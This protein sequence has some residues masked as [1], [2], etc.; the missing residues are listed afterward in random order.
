[1]AVKN[2]IF[3]IPMLTVNSNTF[4]NSFQI[5][6]PGLPNACTLLRIMNKS[7]QDIIVSYDGVTAH[8]YVQAGTTLPITAQLNAQP[9]NF[10]CSFAKGMP[11]YIKG[12]AAG[13]GL[14]YLAGYY[15]PILN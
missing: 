7:N 8:D 15:Q 2:G 11:I 3:A 4:N 5:I 9:N 14:I 13:V 1:M 6:N 12:A 10:V